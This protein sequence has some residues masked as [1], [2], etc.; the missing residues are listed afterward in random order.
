[1]PPKVGGNGA[2]PKKRI[3]SLDEASQRKSLANGG[4][5][6]NRSPL[7]DH[8]SQSNFSIAPLI[9]EGIKVGKL[10]LNDLLKQHM[11]EVKIND[12]QLSRTGTFTL[13]CIDVNSFNKALNELP[14]VL[15]T[16]GHSNAKVFVPRSIQRIKDTERVAFVKRVD[17]D[18][19]EERISKSL[20][21][22]GLECIS[23]NRLR[24]RDGNAPTRTVKI[25]FEDAANRNTFVRTGLQVDSMHFN[26][27]AATHNTKPVQC[28]VC[29]RYN[30]IAKYCKIKQQTCIRCGENHRADQCN[31]GDDKLK[32]CNCKGNHLATSIECSIYK[33]QENRVKKLI[34]QYA[35]ANNNTNI[36][37]PSLTNTHEFPP[38]PNVMRPDF[39]NEIINVLSSKMEKI[40]EETTQRIVNSLQ[41][42]I[43][44][45]EKKLS[46]MN[47]DE[48]TISVSNSDTSFEESEVVKFI[49]KKQQEREREEAEKATTSSKA[50]TTATTT[51][52]KPKTTTTK[53]KKNK[54]ARSANSSMDSTTI[55]YKDLK[56]SNNDD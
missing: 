15:I 34:N 54:R 24:S 8:K 35:T 33:E 16:K 17:L 55:N 3:Q 27:E 25:T 2:A 5:K 26:A 48:G 37:P 12:I 47:E 44:K 6:V 42:K 36:I 13:F 11:P 18:I 7:V 9:L 53:K 14:T 39:F 46:S 40:I 10:E 50:T 29:L 49:R 23:V 1:M 31:V 56:T 28:F 51:N 22:V 4:P 43:E 32:C 21:D 52:T 45:L 41:K 30:H 38:L 20:K 19:P